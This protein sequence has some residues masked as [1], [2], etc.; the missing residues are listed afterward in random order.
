MDEWRRLFRVFYADGGM[1]AHGVSYL[2][3]LD[4]RLSPKSENERAAH[5]KELAECGSGSMPRTQAGMQ[6]LLEDHEA[7]AVR[8]AVQQ[9]ALTL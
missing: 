2:E 9:L 5:F 7:T 3:F 6:K 8:P 4:Q 1:F